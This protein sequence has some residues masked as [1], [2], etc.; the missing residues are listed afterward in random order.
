MGYILVIA[1]FWGDASSVRTI[2][3]KNEALCESARQKALRDLQQGMFP[4]RA[5][6]LKVRESA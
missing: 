3:V 1:I 2:E 6:C 5:T 4:V